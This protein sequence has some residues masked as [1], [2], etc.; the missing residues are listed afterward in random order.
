M[1]W[2][3]CPLPTDLS[4]QRHLF[5]LSYFP[6]NPS[7]SSLIPSA[8]SIAFLNSQK[9]L[10]VSPF[11]ATLTT[12]SQLDDNT[13]TLS[14]A[15]ATLTT[16]IRHKSFACHSCRKHPGWVW[17]EQTFACSPFP[18][19]VALDPESPRFTVAPGI[20]PAL[21]NAPPSATSV[22]SL[23][24]PRT[25]HSAN[26]DSKPLTGSLKPLDATLTK[27]LGEG[28]SANERRCPWLASAS[29][30]G[31]SHAR[32][33]GRSSRYSNPVFH[34]TY[35]CIDTRSFLPHT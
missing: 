28:T 27:N 6:L 31:P 32:L 2:S 11:P 30:Q 26:V 33:K 34:R 18:Q 14:P 10:S 7:Y 29:L 3:N 35:R 9:C 21:L 24:S 1:I 17:V 22:S 13:T 25:G 12:S 4:S 8:P 23:K 20:A 5:A 19:P 15:F 16:Y